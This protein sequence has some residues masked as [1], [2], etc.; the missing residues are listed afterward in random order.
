CGFAAQ[1]R[2]EPGPLV[3]DSGAAP[4]RALLLLTCL[5]GNR[6]CHGWCLMASWCLAS[7]GDA[8]VPFPWHHLP[9]SAAP[10]NHSRLFATAP[11]KARGYSSRRFVSAAKSLLPSKGELRPVCRA[12]SL[13]CPICA[14]RAAFLSRPRAYLDAVVCG[15]RLAV[16]L[17]FHP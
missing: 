2:F 3:V 17:R 14:L 9:S 1:A 6:R 8:Q 15:P 5:W 7:T 11:K 16:R 10:L 13:Y 4:A 12:K